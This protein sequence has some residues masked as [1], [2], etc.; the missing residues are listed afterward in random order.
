MQTKRSKCN[1]ERVCKVTSLKRRRSMWDSQCWIK[2]GEGLRR[3]Q[4]RAKSPRAG[5][6]TCQKPFVMNLSSLWQGRQGSHWRSETGKTL[7]S[8]CWFGFR[9]FVNQLSAVLR[10]YINGTVNEPWICFNWI[11]YRLVRFWYRDVSLDYKCHLSW[12]L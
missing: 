12:R 6:T 3:L 9:S 1:F 8:K 7:L 2:V 10:Y 5:E 4:H 11:P